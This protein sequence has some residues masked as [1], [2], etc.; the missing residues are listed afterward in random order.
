MKHT[1]PLKTFILT[2]TILCLT[3]TLT[4]SQSPPLTVIL[5]WFANPTDGPVLVAQEQHFFQ[6]AGL[7]VKI[8]NPADPDDTPKL[9]ALGKADIG[10][11]SD[12]HMI[13]AVG[14]GLPLL[15]AGTLLDQPMVAVVS[16]DVSKLQDLK[17]KTIGY[18]VGDL[19]K[20]ILG[21]MLNHVGLTLKDVNLIDV[22]FNL[23]Q[24][25]LSKKVDAI[26]GAMRD[27]EVPQIQ[28]MGMK[29]HSFYPENY[30]MPKYAELNYIINTQH[31]NDPRI[32]L[33]L[34][35]IKLATQY[36]NKHPNAAWRGIIA[37]YPQLNTALNKKSWQM[38]YPLFAKDPSYVN[39][40]NFM[41]LV[42]LMHTK[43]WLKKVMPYKQY[44]I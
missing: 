17:G 36:I 33:F 34:R 3:T 13:L 20:F 16:Y 23:V 25:L 31:Q 41:R 43:G 10:I 26:T 24:A 1:S 19:D 35:A 22:H 11:G 27:Y 30:G 12:P 28:M 29:V 44:V 2:C 18:P 6:R 8:I 7:N 32:K 37:Q 4:A 39:H 15:R 5:D 42:N 14:Q 40:A 9:V 38:T 21:V